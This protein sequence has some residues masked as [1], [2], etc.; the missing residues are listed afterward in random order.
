MRFMRSFSIHSWMQKPSWQWNIL[1]MSLFAVV[2]IGYVSWQLEQN[3][4]NF[5]AH[6]LEHARLIGGI[7]AQNS[8]QAQTAQVLY[9]DI[10]GSFLGSTADFMIYLDQIEAFSAAEL[11]AFAW[12]NDLVLIEIAR[13]DGSRVRFPQ[14]WPQNLQLNKTPGLHH[15]HEHHLYSLTRTSAN[16][17][18]TIAIPAYKLEQLQQQLSQEHLLEVIS[19]LPG[20]AYAYTEPAPSATKAQDDAVQMRE[21]QGYPVAEARLPWNDT[22]YLVVGLK[23]KRYHQRRQALFME[24]GGLGS[25]LFSVGGFLSWLLYKQQQHMVRHTKALERQLAQQHEAAALGRSADSISH[26]IRNPLNAIS[27]GLQRIEMEASLEREHTDLLQAM[28]QALKRSNAIITQLQRFARPL[29]PEYQRVNLATISATVLDLYRPM[30]QLSNIEVETDIAP[31]S[32]DADPALLQRALDN[33]IK[34]AIEAQPE[35]GRIRLEIK[36]QGDD[37]VSISITNTIDPDASIDLG[38]ILEP[39]VSSKARGTG[40]G[41]PVVQK[42]IRAHNGNIHITRPEAGWFCVAI[43]IPAQK[44]G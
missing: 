11:E 36:R 20:M 22:E 25:I 1:V 42:I 16:V 5:R 21:V 39:Y 29:Q 23:A 33:L 12:E 9:T 32:I 44:H 35:G 14:Q 13:R 26:E 24:L 6:T 38:A 27:M 19:A 2:A 43:I 34:N 18:L 10:I 31:L 30:A 17:S 28:Q 15:L 8:A 37:A 7:M 3:R 4:Q 41:L 40:L